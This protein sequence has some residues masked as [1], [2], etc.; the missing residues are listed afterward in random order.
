[1]KRLLILLPLSALLLLGGCA[2][3]EAAA[4]PAELVEF[5]P[6]VS[7]ARDWQ[8]RAGSGD[9]KRY[10]RLAPLVRDGR[11]YVSERAGTVRA[12]EVERGRPAW[13]RD[14]G[15]VLTSAPGWGAHLYV[16]GSDGTVLALD[17]ATGEEVWRARITSEVLA[18]P[19]EHNGVVVVRSVDGRLTGL[20]ATQGRRLWVYSR[21]VPVLTLRGTSAPVLLD[22]AVIA[23]FDSGQLTAVSLAEGSLLW[24]IPVG[25]PRGRNEL[26]RMVDLDADP[27]VVGPLAYAASYQGRVAAIDL[28]NG[29]AVWTRDISVYAGLTGDVRLQRGT[30]EGTVYVTDA[31]SHVWALDARTGETLWRQE[32]L[33][34]RRLS[35]PA[36]H[37]DYVVVGDFE[38]YLHWFA[39]EDGRLVA[40][41]RADRRGV[42]AAPVVEGERVFVHGRGGR[43]SA[44]RV[45]G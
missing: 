23:G 12:Y 29:R 18:P 19:R 26:E 31:D 32:E 6:T 24:E 2:T 4:P 34:G 30:V 7:V 28:T 38:G 21:S 13:E 8:R 14:T 5:E 42:L 11:V 17:A 36:I 41:E 43:L 3:R 25:V 37:G 27:L 15:L 35:G 9:D 20:D 40:R 39:R 22:D 10:L 44:W 1:M 33:R 16:G 45:R